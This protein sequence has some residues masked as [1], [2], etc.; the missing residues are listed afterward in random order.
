MKKKKKKNAGKGMLQLFVF[1]A[2]L[3][4]PLA[5]AYKVD[6]STVDGVFSVF[7]R[8]SEFRELYDYLK[9]VRFGWKGKSCAVV[10]EVDGRVGGRERRERERAKER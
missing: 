7:H 1:T 4:I 6:I 8:Y 5:Q 9:E 2:S 10:V 3:M